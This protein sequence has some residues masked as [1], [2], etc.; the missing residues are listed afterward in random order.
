MVLGKSTH[1]TKSPNT[2]ISTYNN[3]IIPVGRHIDEDA[4]LS[5]S[6]FPSSSFSSEQH[7][8]PRKPSTCICC[9]DRD[10][11][12]KNDRLTTC[13][14]ISL[15]LILFIVSFMVMAVMELNLSYSL[16]ST[17]SSSSS[18]IPFSSPPN[19][20]SS[21]NLFDNVE[22]TNVILSPSSSSLSTSLLDMNFVR[23][24]LSQ[25]ESIKKIDDTT[26]RVEFVTEYIDDDVRI[27][28]EI[29]SKRIVVEYNNRKKEQEETIDHHDRY[30]SSPTTVMIPHDHVSAECCCVSNLVDF[31]GPI[32]IGGALNIRWGYELDCYIAKQIIKSNDDDDGDDDHHEHD[33]FHRTLVIIFNE[34][35]LK[36][37]DVQC[38]IDWHRTTHVKEISPS[39]SPPPILQEEGDMT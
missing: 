17:S 20:L 5:F 18:F 29:V 3:S 32:V 28:Y 1:A 8:K 33:R 24:I 2:T 6:A 34:K 15:F 4:F 21:I 23:R 27:V 22:K 39:P 36:T 11:N 38:H 19:T 9:H 14:W 30:A 37:S 26:G 16:S 35:L 12:I 7:P 13:R 25:T 10:D 31:C